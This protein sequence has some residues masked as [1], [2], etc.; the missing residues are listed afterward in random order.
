LTTDPNQI[1]V[2]ITFPYISDWKFLSTDISYGT[3]YTANKIYALVQIVAN[4]GFTK[5]SDVKPDASK[6]RI[7]DITSGITT[8]YGDNPLTPT[9]MVKQSFSIALSNYNGFAQYNLKDY[10]TKYPTKQPN[11]DNELCF[12]D[13]TFF[14]GNVETSIKAI[15]YTLDVPIVLNLNEFNSSTNAT[16]NSKLDKDVYISEIGIYDTQKNLVGIGKLNNP[17][18]KDSSKARTIVFDVDF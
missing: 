11:A 1:S 5:M 18:Q 7:T 17:I 10:L 12:G 16:W 14:L 2:V 4:S 13:E 9:E 3:G 15:A 6:W 8:H